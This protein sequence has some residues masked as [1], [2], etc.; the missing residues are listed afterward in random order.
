MNKKILLSL[1]IIGMIVSVASAGTWA[2][3]SD[4]E[5]STSNTLT[6]GSLILDMPTTMTITDT[7]DKYI[8]PGEEGSGSITMKNSGTVAGDLYVKINPTTSELLPYIDLTAT[9]GSTRVGL[10]DQYVK[11]ADL[12]AGQSA[13]LSVGYSMDKDQ[14]NGQGTKAAFKIDVLLMQDGITPSQLSSSSNS[15]NGNGNGGHNG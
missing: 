2:Y 10:D 1:L 14:T 6:A 5:T 11:V 8:V 7:A 13:T 12:A 4:T 9:V 3:F 15:G